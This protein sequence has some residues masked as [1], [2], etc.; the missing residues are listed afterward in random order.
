MKTHLSTI[1]FACLGLFVGFALCFVYLVVP[2][3]EAT[4]AALAARQSTEEG[5]VISI[6]A[7]GGL[8]VGGKLVDMNRLA[9]LLK[10]RRAQ[11][12]PVRINADEHAPFSVIVKVL[13]ACKAA[14]VG[15][16]VLMSRPNSQF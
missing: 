15:T 7:N 12:Q 10:Q 14:G 8:R 9:T 5:I 4:R 3:R 16:G 1:V 11:G 2:Q 6:D 13:D